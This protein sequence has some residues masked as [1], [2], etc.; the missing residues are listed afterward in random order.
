[1]SGGEA[2][3][4]KGMERTRLRKPLRSQYKGTRPVDPVLLAP[5]AKGTAPGREHPIPKHAQTREVPWY[6]VVVEVAPHD[7]LEP[8]AGL[9]HG[10]AHPLTALLL[11]FSQLRPHAFA[12]RLAP[13]HAPAPLPSTAPVE[14]GSPSLH[15]LPRNCRR[16]TGACPAPIPTSTHW[17]TI[18]SNSSSN[19][20]DS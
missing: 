3:I 15:W 18:C 10:I 16:P 14:C 11:N 7:R 20:F 1:M 2:N 6:C 13:H 9:A 5:A 19:S 8:L 12:N 4:R 17:R